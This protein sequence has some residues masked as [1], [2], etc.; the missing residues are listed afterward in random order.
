MKIVLADPPRKESHYDNSYPN[1]GILYLISYLRKYCQTP[2]ELVYLE[3]DCTLEQHLNFV[4]AQRPDIYGLSFAMWTADLAYKTLSA[5]KQRLPQTLTI[6]GGPEPTANHQLVFQNS[7]VDICVL[8]EG[9][10]TLNQ[11]VEALASGG[12]LRQVPG[13][14][15]RQEGAEALTTPKRQL[16][17]DLEE[18]PLPAWDLV[19][20]AKYSGMHINKSSPQT[21]MLV[22]RGCP[23]DCN[24]CANPVWKLN[25]PWVRMRQPS[26]IAAEVKLLYD[27][28]VREIYMTSDEFNVSEKWSLEVCQAIKSL[29]LR[30]LYFQ[31]NLR[32]DNV[33]EKL[34]QAFSG[35][36]L[37]LIHLGIESG[38]QR[39]LDGIGKHITIEQIERTCRIMQAA[40]IKVFGFVMLFHA[41]EENGVL[42]FETPADVHKTLDFCRR[43]LSRKLIQYMS[44]QVATPMPGSR[45]H[46]TAKKFNLI[47][48]KKITGVWAQNLLLPGVKTDEVKKALRRG[49]LLKNYYLLK[50]GNINLSHFSRALRNLKVIFGR[51]HG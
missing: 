17:A 15:L 45:L 1:I 48:D 35:I 34:A 14:A 44:W 4:E 13:L 40:N 8:G 47:P 49:M 21:H 51:Q 38:N 41:W 5:V 37:W 31:C 50:N 29:G 26:S 22:S 9:E 39:T 18:I 43:L 16:I 23:F 2:L 24:F 11:L 30:D 27:K 12:D 33:S 3:G 6:C 10:A 7:T 32:A 46:A 28:G 42:Q 36:N 20:L 25:K 19:D